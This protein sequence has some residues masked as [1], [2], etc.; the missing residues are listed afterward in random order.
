MSETI[1]SLLKTILENK[2]D[3]IY[4]SLNFLQ[5]VHDMFN[6][7]SHIMVKALLIICDT[8]SLNI[9]SITKQQFDFLVQKFA[10]AGILIN[11]QVT[12]NPTQMRSIRTYKTLNEHD[13]LEDYSIVISSESVFRIFFSLKPHHTSASCSRRRLIL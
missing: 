1:D 10:L 12:P 4:L 13:M 5:D 6:F 3:I 7:F 9:D 11:L 8:T 2:T